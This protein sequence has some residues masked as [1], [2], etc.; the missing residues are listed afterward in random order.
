M[1]HGWATP[2]G[3]EVIHAFLWRHGAI[4]DLGTLTNDPCSF[5]FS[6]SI[7][8]RGQIVGVSN[9]CDDPEHPFLWE[10]GEPMVD[11][12]S[13][14][15]PVSEVTVTSPIFINDRGEITETDRRRALNYKVTRRFA[16][17][18]V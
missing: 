17:G 9:V 11:L 18:T 15:V 13:L 12:N 5:S 14:V 7:N 3:D 16:P 6:H 8:S 2:P 1:D 10:N 4:T